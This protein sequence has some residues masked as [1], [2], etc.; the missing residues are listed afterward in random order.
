[1]HL[2]HPIYKNL[3]DI[4]PR[5]STNLIGDFLALT[6]SSLCLI[7]CL[8]LP[9]AVAFGP[10]IANG[11]GSPLFHKIMVIL[12]IPTSI[13][14]FWRIKTIP[15][16][17]LLLVGIGL[18]GLFCGAFIHGLEAFETQI[19]VVSALMIMFGHLVRY[20]RR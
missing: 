10:L 11:I 20:I 1:M 9:V 14:A 18:I 2:P 12:A 4:K 3:V 17:S 16:L 13:Y 6:F 15:P 19:T 7:H 8:F 5:G